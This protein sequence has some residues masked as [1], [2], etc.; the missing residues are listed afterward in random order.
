MYTV[1]VQGLPKDGPKPTSH[2]LLTFTAL[3][4]IAVIYIHHIFINGD[5]N[6]ALIL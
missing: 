2:Q 5:E 6:D 4:I 1:H 3:D